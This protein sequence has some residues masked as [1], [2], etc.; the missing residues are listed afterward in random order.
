VSRAEK[1]KIEICESDQCVAEFESANFSLTL[2]FAPRDWQRPLIDDR[3]QRIVAIV[4]RRA[5]KSI[6]LMW[7]GIKRAVTET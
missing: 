2:P 1:A 7:R 3:A 5:G 6:G 4:H